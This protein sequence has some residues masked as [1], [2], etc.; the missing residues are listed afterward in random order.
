MLTLVVLAGV[1]EAKPDVVALD[2]VG[3]EAGGICPGE[4]HRLEIAEV[5]ARGRER[6]IRPNAR[7]DLQ[8]DWELGEVSDKGDL[9]GPTDPRAAWGSSGVL[10]VSSASDPDLRAQ[11]EIP[12]RYDCTVT[13]QAHGRDGYPGEQGPN[14]IPAN[15]RGTDG[16]RGH[17]GDAGGDAPE[18]H[19]RATIVPEPRTGEEVLQVEIEVLGED[20]LRYA[21][22]HPGTGE[23][24][25]S[26]LGGRGGQ[27][28]RGGDG[29]D[30]DGATGGSGAE[31]GAGGIGGRGGVV[32][33]FVDSSAVGRVRNIIV[34]NVGGPGGAGGQPGNA[35]AGG[36]N[37]VARPGRPGIPGAQGPSGP[38]P[39][40]MR[41][42]VEPIW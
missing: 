41:S 30:S 28:G 18:L 15:P 5:D 23:L 14:G 38:A 29:G 19:L 17:P 20:E 4:V 12:L 24:V 39:E 7:G 34:E 32:R 22:I 16:Q 33:V 13:V 1:A 2:L 10:T 37:N 26:A 9:T 40:V 11:L 6:R 21:A 36:E 35:G 42:R 31:G 27:G 25:L 3:P 8:F